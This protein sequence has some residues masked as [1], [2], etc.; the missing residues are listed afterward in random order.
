VEWELPEL[1]ISEMAPQPEVEF[2]ILY[3]DAYLAVID[4][5][6]GL[7]VH[8]APGHP[9]GTLVNG[10]LARLEG[11]SGVGGVERP[12]LVHRLDKDTSGL[13]VVA[14]NDEAHLALQAQLKDRTLTRIYRAICW[15]CPDPDQGSIDA[16][17]D[18]HPR[19]RL[20]RAVVQD[21]REALTHYRV[22][23]RHSGSALLELRLATGR[24]HQIRVHLAHIGHPVLGDE[25]YGGG[26]QR[27]RGAHSEHRPALRAALLS[28]G[29]QALHAAELAF[30]HPAREERMV[31]QS[32]LPEDFR[33]GLA[34]LRE[35][36][37][38]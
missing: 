20:R 13:L 31:F 9:Q 27:L 3:E 19:D 7:V 2:G 37:P 29:R 8:P 32:P 18:R 4:K 25:L 12:G 16:P 36:S 15:G 6:V 10:L 11:L 17:L 34:V 26:L 28:I 1:E 24:T 5:P 23:E 21:G 35:G 30:L 38:R 33:V 22:E 14:K